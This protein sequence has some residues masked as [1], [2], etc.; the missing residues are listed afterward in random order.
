MQNIQTIERKWIGILAARV[1][2]HA[3]AGGLGA[4]G[5]GA[6]CIAL[7][8]ALT[9]AVIDVQGMPSHWDAGMVPAGFFV[10]A[11]LGGIGG[12][13]AGMIA[14]ALLGFLRVPDRH[15]LPRRAT[16]LA[17]WSGQ[18][19]GTLGICFTFFLFAAMAAPV[20]GKSFSASVDTYLM[21]IMFGAP[22]AMIIGEIAGAVWSFNFKPKTLSKL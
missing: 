8:G 10:G 9:G 2:S 11:V 15:F 17:I 5:V 21:W 22:A 14:F 6:I 12:G 19:C 20:A 13:V 1:A 7:A 4:A 3:L 18:I 16:F